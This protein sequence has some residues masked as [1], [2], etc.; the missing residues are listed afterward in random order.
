MVA[1]DLFLVGFWFFTEATNAATAAAAADDGFNSSPD[2]ASLLVGSVVTTLSLSSSLTDNFGRLG[3]FGP[4]V[5]TGPVV[6]GAVTAGTTTDFCLHVVCSED[7]ANGGGN[8]V[9]VFFRF[10]FALGKPVRL[11]VF[12]RRAFFLFTASLSSA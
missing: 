5:A 4:L 2:G 7:V 10:F 11:N 8:G 12:R 6:A 3:F 1:R 9:G